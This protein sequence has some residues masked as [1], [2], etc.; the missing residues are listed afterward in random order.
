VAANPG[1]LSSLG[2]ALGEL[3]D[4]GD[5]PKAQDVP[6]LASVLR[7]LV[8]GVATVALLAIAVARPLRAR[9]VAGAA[10]AL[11]AL[12]LLLL[13]RGYHPAV[14]EQRADP[15]APPAVRFLQREAHGTRVAAE[16]EAFGPNTPTRYGLAE[17]GGHEL[18]VVERHQRLWAA[19]G[20]GGY[21]RTTVDPANPSAVKLLD[22][23][24]VRYAISGGLADR[25]LR[26]AFA[27]PG[28][29]VVE[30]HSALPRAFVAYRW[31]SARTMADALGAVAA[32]PSS[33]ARSEPVVEK[34]GPPPAGPPR[35]PSPARVV[36]A[37]DTEVKVSLTARAPGLLVLG[38]T[39]YPGWKA[40]VDG[41][42]AE[43][44]PANG[45]FRA[46]RVPAGRHSVRFRYRPASVYAGAGISLAALLA[47][48]AALAWRR[49]GRT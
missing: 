28:G 23:F 44:R 26:T 35:A 49:P 43:I 36:R 9:A 47:L 18:P 25:G 22:L 34:L 4:L 27:G 21:Q 38:D 5:T 3:P 17:A 29:P 46:V 39:Y 19:L 32:S 12:D 30:I 6:A 40:D 31:R 16:N 41:R 45:A 33:Q 15:P 7:W 2:D 1:A 11:A 48:A 24:G 20:G 13:A 10:V 14:P 8:L 37:T 42:G